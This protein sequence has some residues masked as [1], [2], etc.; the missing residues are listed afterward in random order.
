MR[1]KLR[2]AYEN[3]PIYYII[4]VVN[5]VLFFR[6]VVTL[7]IVTVGGYCNRVGR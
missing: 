3:I 7:F 2:S 6:G 4:T 1:K 5:P